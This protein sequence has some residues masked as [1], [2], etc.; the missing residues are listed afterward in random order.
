M[1]I[2]W[3]LKSI[4]ATLTRNITQGL[5]FVETLCSSLSPRQENHCRQTRPSGGSPPGSRHTLSCFSFLLFQ[6]LFIFKGPEV[7]SYLSSCLHLET[8]RKRIQHLGHLNTLFW[9]QK[10]C[11]RIHWSWLHSIHVTLY[12]AGRFI[13]YLLAW[14]KCSCTRFWSIRTL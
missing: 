9:E 6:G 7:P 4:Y 11:R 5:S 8:S 2:K 1:I 13:V 12:E 3:K 14:Y 10:I